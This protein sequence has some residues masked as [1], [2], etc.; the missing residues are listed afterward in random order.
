M[1]GQKSDSCVFVCKRHRFSLILR[2]WYLILKLFW[3]CAIFVFC[4]SLGKYIKIE[5]ISS[6]LT[7]FNTGLKEHSRSHYL[8][9]HHVN[10]TLLTISYQDHLCTQKTLHKMRIDFNSVI[11]KFLFFSTQSLILRYSY[12]CSCFSACVVILEQY[13]YAIGNIFRYLFDMM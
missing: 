2:F 9:I 1:P 8:K 11:W 4:F 6:T 3:Q 7:G 12:V 5:Y 13:I 10:M